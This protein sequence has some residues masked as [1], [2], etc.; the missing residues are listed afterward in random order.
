MGKVRMPYGSYGGIVAAGSMGF[1]MRILPSH[2]ICSVD[3]HLSPGDFGNTRDWPEYEEF[4]SRTCPSIKYL[5]ILARKAAFLERRC[6]VRASYRDQSTKL[7][8]LITSLVIGNCPWWQ[9]SL[10]QSTSCSFEYDSRISGIFL[11]L[12]FKWIHYMQNLADRTK[13]HTTAR[14]K[15]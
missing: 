4:N 9:W 3:T 13:P 7:F 11:R 8:K 10:K 15:A 5:S 14:N 12:S 2:W 6:I 1:C